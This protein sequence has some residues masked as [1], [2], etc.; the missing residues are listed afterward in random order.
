MKGDFF[1]IFF[2]KSDRPRG[3][4]LGVGEYTLWPPIGR[5]IL[6]SIFEMFH[7]LLGWYT[8]YCAAPLVTGTSERKHNKTSRLIGRHALYKFD[9]MAYKKLLEEVL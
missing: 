6:L 2:Y 9:A 4:E 7:W 3:Q 8:S 1:L 5:D